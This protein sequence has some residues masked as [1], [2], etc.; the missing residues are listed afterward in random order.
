MSE[1]VLIEKETPHVCSPRL[2]FLLDNWIR[3]RFQQPKKILEGYIREGDTVIDMG[4]GPGF[5]SLEMAKKVGDSGKLIAIDLQD[6]MLSKVMKKAIK[7]GLE[8]RIDV[9]RCRPD[10]IGLNRKA[11]FM[12]A[13]Y[14]V[15]ETPDPGRFF[16][17]SR[18]L[19][20]GKGRLLVVEPR[21]HVKSALFQTLV[22][23]GET[24]GLKAI[25]FPKRKGGRAVLFS[26]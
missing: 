2:A 11:D 26:F 21:F 18:G 3:R 16:K 15:H 1:S 24:A 10:S 7:H 12:L 4:C 8:K 9:H 20:K 22:S 5:F 13:F 25:D 6:E 23:M 17:E 14:M 19:L